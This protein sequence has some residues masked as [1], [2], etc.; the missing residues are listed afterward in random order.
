MKSNMAEHLVHIAESSDTYEALL[1]CGN[2]LVDGVTTSN[3]TPARVAFNGCL[4]SKE[5]EAEHPLGAVSGVVVWIDPKCRYEHRWSN[6]VPGSDTVCDAHDGR[7]GC[8][9][10]LAYVGFVCNW[11]PNVITVEENGIADALGPANGAIER[12]GSCVF[13]DGTRGLWILGVRG[14]FDAVTFSGLTPDGRH[15]SKIFGKGLRR[16]PRLM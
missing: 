3:H 6:R 7:D 4:D 11:M 12:S 15:F 16:G 13:G 10:D 14:G 8:S 1:D 9:G 2:C 5:L